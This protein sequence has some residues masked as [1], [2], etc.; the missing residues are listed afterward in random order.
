[1]PTSGWQQ[2][3]DKL[4]GALP[5]DDYEA[6]AHVFARAADLERTF[7]SLLA[8]AST[9]RGL[10][11]EGMPVVGLADLAPEVRGVLM[12]ADAA[13]GILGALAYEGEKLPPSTEPDQV[14]RQERRLGRP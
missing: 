2:Q 8:P 14:D 10:T 4:A 7:Q 3:G 5:P 9:R 11:R 13:R 6:V 1:M 12:Q